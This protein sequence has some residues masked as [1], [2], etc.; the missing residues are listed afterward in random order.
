MSTFTAGLCYFICSQ[1]ISWNNELSFLPL[2][3]IPSKDHIIS[4]HILHAYYSTFWKCKENH[5]FYCNH[6]QCV[7]CLVDNVKFWIISLIVSL[8]GVRYEETIHFIMPKFCPAYIAK[9]EVV[10]WLQ[11]KVIRIGRSVF[12]FL[13][14]AS[15]SQRMSPHMVV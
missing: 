10:M 14:S 8:E 13:F 7:G 4:S 11:F 15:L 2:S 12:A 5:V 3:P 6:L 1:N 9:Y